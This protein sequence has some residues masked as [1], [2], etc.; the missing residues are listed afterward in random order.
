MTGGTEITGGGWV[1]RTS[2]VRS[3]GD[4]VSRGLKSVQTNF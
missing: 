3:Q 4:F 2:G 1:R